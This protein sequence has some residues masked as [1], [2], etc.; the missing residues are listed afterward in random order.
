MKWLPAFGMVQMSNCGRYTV[1]NPTDQWIAYYIPT[2][3]E[4]E[5]LGERDSDVK[6]R[7]LCEAHE[8][9]LIAAHR[10]SA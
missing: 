8:S 7:G 6:A 1:Q 9:Q 10:R 5:K 3:G 4:P 2:Y